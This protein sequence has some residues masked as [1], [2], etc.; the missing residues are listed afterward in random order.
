MWPPPQFL[1]NQLCLL[2]VRHRGLQ[3]RRENSKAPQEEKDERPLASDASTKLSG[4]RNQLR[5]NT[6]GLVYEA[7]GPLSIGCFEAPQ[8]LRPWGKFPFWPHLGSPG[9][10]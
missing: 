6:T 1:R 4:S 7:L 8:T 5:K 9:G 2:L 3:A 10:R